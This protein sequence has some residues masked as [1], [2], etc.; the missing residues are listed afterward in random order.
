MPCSG[1]GPEHSRPLAPI[2]TRS[3]EQNGTVYTLAVDLKHEGLRMQLAWLASCH[4]ADETDR[5]R[6]QFLAVTSEFNIS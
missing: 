4:T 2:V 6:P 3:R 5:K 1:P